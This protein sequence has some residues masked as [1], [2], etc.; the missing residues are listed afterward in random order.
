MDI[1]VPERLQL[2]PFTLTGAGRLDAG[3]CALVG[4]SPAVVIGQ[5]WSNDVG[6]PSVA[7]SFVDRLGVGIDALADPAQFIELTIELA[8][9]D[10]TLALSIAQ[11][12]VIAA[13]ARAATDVLVGA[14]AGL[15]AGGLGEQ[16]LDV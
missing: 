9:A 4:L 1:F 11:H 10:G 8:P 13:A 7:G 12:A 3:R 16:S 6:W 2:Q 15:A 5:G 14:P